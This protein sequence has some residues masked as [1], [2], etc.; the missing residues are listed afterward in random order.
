MLKDVASAINDVYEFEFLAELIPQSITY[1]EAM[2]KRK[3]FEAIEAQ[4]KEL[5]DA[6][7]TGLI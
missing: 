4:K 2:E 1:K 7:G 5:E 3:Q 6:L